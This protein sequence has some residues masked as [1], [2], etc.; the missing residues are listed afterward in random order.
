VQQ[1]QFPA[2]MH[3]VD[4]ADEEWDIFLSE[5]QSSLAV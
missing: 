1:K 3:T 2:E 5:L 4:M